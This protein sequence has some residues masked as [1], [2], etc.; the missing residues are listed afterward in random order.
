MNISSTQNNETELP[1]DNPEPSASNVIIQKIVNNDIVEL[2]SF[3][4]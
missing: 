2:L 1:N 4:I 3:K